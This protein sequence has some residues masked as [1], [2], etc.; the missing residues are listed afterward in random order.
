MIRF[1]QNLMMLRR[2]PRFPS[3]EGYRDFTAIFALEGYRDF[4]PLKGM[5][6]RVP[7]FAQTGIV[8]IA[9]KRLAWFVEDIFW[10]EPK[11]SASLLAS[12][13]TFCRVSVFS[14]RI[15]LV[16]N[17]GSGQNGSKKP[18][19]CRTAEL[20]HRRQ[21]HCRARGSPRVQA[22]A[23]EGERW[24]IGCFTGEISGGFYRVSGIFLTSFKPTV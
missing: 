8:E 14:R 12:P 15:T 7:R 17:F 11:S 6:R 20:R 21:R 22:S 9:G 4:P 1:A 24:L 2:V 16:K 3:L 19:E 13:Y 5:L 23:S 18:T 10:D